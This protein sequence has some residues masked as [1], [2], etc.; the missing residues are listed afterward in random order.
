[1]CGSG[2][3]AWSLRPR[4]GCVTS[5]E[6]ISLIS[7]QTQFCVNFIALWSQTRAF[8]HRTSV[9]FLIGLCSDQGYLEK[10]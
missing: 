4:S 10:F 2:E 1:M 3:V 6:R 7:K 8:K 9:S 5:A